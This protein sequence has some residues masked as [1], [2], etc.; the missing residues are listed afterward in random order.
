MATAERTP[1]GA[2]Q[3]RLRRRFVTPEGVDLKLDL[4][5]A[6]NEAPALGKKR[7]QR[8]VHPV[9]VLPDFRHRRALGRSL[10]HSGLLYGEPD[11]RGTVRGKGVAMSRDKATCR[12]GG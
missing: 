3:A 10:G 8:L 9:D 4:G 6:A 11:S 1:N 2:G 12:P 7:H 5:G